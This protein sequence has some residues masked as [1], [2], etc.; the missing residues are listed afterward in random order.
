MSKDIELQERLGQDPSPKEVTVEANIEEGESDIW[1]FKMD[2][3]EDIITT[4][5]GAVFIV[6]D[7]NVYRYGKDQVQEMVFEDTGLDQEEGESDDE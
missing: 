4:T 7:G 6:D 1:T 5:S 3:V 2:Q